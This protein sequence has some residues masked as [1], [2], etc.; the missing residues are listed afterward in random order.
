MEEIGKNIFEKISSYNILNN[1]F[2]G[3]IFCYMI[4]SFT[5]Y[6]LITQNNW[7][8]IFVYY[9]FGVVISRV[10]SVLI[11]EILL[12]I[13]IRNKQTKLKEKYINR[14]RYEDYISVSEKQPFVQILNE[15]NNVYRTMISLFTCVLMAKLC[16][17]LSTYISAYT[18]KIENVQ[19]MLL[20]MAGLVLFV[21]SYKKQTDYIR[22][23]VQQT[24]AREDD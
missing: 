11:E 9:F 23:R 3:I 16:E 5:S 20:L 14:V 2:P 21:V 6:D 17:V 15:T 19:D 12:R 24:I 1:L 7:E 13:K 22:N 4:K 10:G 18:G 8:N